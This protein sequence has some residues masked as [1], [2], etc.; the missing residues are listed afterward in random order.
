MTQIDSLLHQIQIINTKNQEILDATGARF[1]MFKLCGVNHYE[2][3]H[4]SILAEFLNPSGSHGL[5]MKFLKAFID[6]FASDDIKNSFAFDKAQVITE[7]PTNF[8]RIDIVIKDNQQ[9]ILILEN[10]IYAVDQFEQLKR[11]HSYAQKYKKHEIFYLT[12]TGSEASEHSGQNVDYT[13]LSYAVQIIHWLEQCVLIAVNHPIV[14]ETI[15]QYINHLK[16]LTNQDMDAKNSE[17]LSNLILNS[18]SNFAAF[19]ILMQN[20]GKI[21]QRLINDSAKILEEEVVKIVALKNSLK[22]EFDNDLYKG[23][24]ESYVRFFDENILKD[25]YITIEFQEPNLRL[26]AIACCVSTTKNERHEQLSHHFLDLFNNSYPELEHPKFIFSLY[27]KSDDMNV[28]NNIEFDKLKFNKDA[29]HQLIESLDQIIKRLL[30]VVEL[31][32]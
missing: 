9:N 20:Q 27:L 8:G 24:K 16:N 17:E 26:P 2:N 10:K 14:R 30:N 22:Y 15:N 18:E 1:N 7:Y 11:Y 23:L 3:T 19:N 29:V 25:L 31:H 32:Y 4:S 28:L 5:S 13:R 21:Y 12:L 6:L